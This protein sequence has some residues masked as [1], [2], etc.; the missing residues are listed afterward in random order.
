MRGRAYPTR[1]VPLYSTL[2]ESWNYK[3][4]VYNYERIIYIVSKIWYNIRHIEEKGSHA[5]EVSY[6][7]LWHRLIDKEMNKTD[8]RLAIGVSSATIARLT[9]NEAVSMEVLMRICNALDCDVGDI[10]EIIKGNGDEPAKELLQWFIRRLIVSC[11][12][13][14]RAS[15]TRSRAW[16]VLSKASYHVREPSAIIIVSKCCTSFVAANGFYITIERSDSYEEYVFSDSE[17]REKD[18]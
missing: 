11:Q 9:N 6:K 5:V 4:C 3:W 18:V 16:I 1:G 17:K 7:K 13:G 15:P 2:I 14:I 12:I 8:L 10:M